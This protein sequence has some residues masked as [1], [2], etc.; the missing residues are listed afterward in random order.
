[1]AIIRD[2]LSLRLTT[3][4]VAAARYFYTDS[5]GRDPQELLKKPPPSFAM[6]STQRRSTMRFP[7]FFRRLFKFTSMDFETVRWE[8]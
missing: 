6:A 1:M 2:G 4:S 8:P 7:P 3:W 5:T